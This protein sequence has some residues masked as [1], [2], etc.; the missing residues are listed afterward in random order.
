MRNDRDGFA[1]PVALFALVVVGILVTGGFYMANQETRISHSGERAT[2]AFYNA[3][4]GIAHALSRGWDPGYVQLEAWQ[5]DT[6]Q[7]TDPDTYGHWAATVTSLGG[8]LFMVT[9]EGTAAAN[10]NNGTASRRASKMVRLPN[11]DIDVPGALMTR[12]QINVR[13]NAEIHGTDTEPTHWSEE[14]CPTEHADRPGI[15]IDD[16]DNVEE[17]GN[18]E[19]EG[20]PPLE[21]DP[22]M[23]DEDFLEFGELDWED[24]TAPEMTDYQ[25]SGNITEAPEPSLT[26]DEDTG[27]WHC[28]RGDSMN[29]GDPEFVESDP[30]DVDRYPC[31]NHFPIIHIDGDASLEAGG[32]GQGILL[33]DGNLNIRG[34]F[35]FYGIVV[36]QGTF[37]TEGSG[38]RIVGGVMAAADAEVDDQTYAGGSVVQSSGCAQERARTLAQASR[39]LA[40]EGRS[41]ADITAGAY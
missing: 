20:D 13:G 35:T 37:E 18:P 3:E 39:P 9:S 24:L 36:V 41:W 25:F 22:D 14:H 16:L 32:V 4:R 33:V 21:E 11:L 6:I 17:D 31:A 28:D 29:W 7:P 15:V 2:E 1:L 27:E 30:D 34:D 10:P 19:I 40:L 23:A 26:Q 5:A 8:N 38:N 12:G